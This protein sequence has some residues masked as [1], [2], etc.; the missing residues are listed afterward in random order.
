MPDIIQLLPD[1]VANQ[2]AAGEV[3]QRPASVVKELVENAIDAGATEIHVAITD[4]GRTS[5]RV[6]D[7][8]TGMSPTDA[9]MAFERHAT[10]KIRKAD[11]LFSLTTMGFRGEA[12]ASIAAVAMVTVKTKRESDKLGIE[13]RIDGSR[14]IDQQPLACPTGT[15]VRV[16]NL[17]YN[18]PARRKFLKSNATETTNIVQTFQRIALIYPTLTFTLTVADHEQYHL[19]PGSMLTRVC[20]VFGKRF[21]DK[22]LPVSADTTVCK[23]EGYIARPEAARKK[24]AQQFFFVNGRYMRHPYFNRAIASAYDRLLPEGTQA[25]Y[26]IAFTVPP[27]QIDV[28]IHPVKTEIK[29]DDEQTVWSILLA[30]VR[31]AV[32]TVTTAT[33]LDFDTEG[34]PDIPV[35]NP[36]TATE[37]PHIDFN[38]R[39]NPFD[40]HTTRPAAKGWDQ[41]FPKQQNV[42]ASFAQR[43][44]AP[45]SFSDGLVPDENDNGTSATRQPQCEKSVVSVPCNEAVFQTLGRYL[46]TPAPDGITITDQTRASERV[47]YEQ[48]LDAL[49]RRTPHTQRLLFPEAI[50][51]TPDRAATFDTI[52][53]DIAAIG[54]QLTPAEAD[55]TYNIEGVPAGLGGLDPVALL[56]DIITQTAE[57]QQDT[58]DTQAL[59]TDIAAALA[60]RAATPEGEYLEPTQAQT[61]LAALAACTNKTY[62]PRGLPIATTLSAEDINKL[63]SRFVV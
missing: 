41:L 19:L 22:L 4:A 35:F 31:D 57:S 51:I 53:G 59:H 8:G 15:T 9:R 13:M 46:I 12:L 36:T 18:I 3:I 5:I 28:N 61:L 56:T 25:P 21:K 6:T 54:F 17:F 23:I 47:L 50:T 62:T 63:F 42:A 1:S 40:T 24:G 55:G 52:R 20:D 37:Q 26:F 7:N 27:D 14:F 58:V 33:T 43:R 60:H 16:D 2:I 49:T 29:F 11:D 48:Y 38:P 45:L 30:A 34:R 39:Y 44:D 32:G 10:S